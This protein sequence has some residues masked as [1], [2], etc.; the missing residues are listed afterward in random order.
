MTFNPLE[1]L[2]WGIRAPGSWITYSFM[3]G[4]QPASAD[5]PSQLTVAWNDYEKG[6]VRQALE[7]FSRITNLRFGEIALDEDGEPEAE[8]ML[9]LNLLD[10]NDPALLGSC[11]PLGRPEPAQARFN[12]G[13]DSWSRGPGGDLDAGGDGFQTLIHEFGHGLGLSHPHDTGLNGD[14]PIFPGVVDPFGR[15]GYGEHD[16]NQDVWTMMSYVAG[17]PTGPD[18]TSG[19][20]AWGEAMAPMAFD[21][22]VLQAKYG[23]N[24]AWATGDDVYELAD[25]DGPGTGYAAIWDAGGSDTI[26]YGGARDAVI[27]L[28]AATL[29]WAPGGAGQVSYVA[30]VHGG[31]TIAHGVVI[32]NAAG[33]AGDDILRGN[34]ADNILAGGLG[35]DVLEGGAGRDTAAYGVTLAAQSQ[36][37]GMEGGAHVLAG[38]E[39]RD[40][41]RGIEVFAFADG[42]L[43]LDDGTILVDDLL[44]AIANPD[45]W[46]AGLDAE[47]HYGAAGWREG[48]DPNL[49]FST[50]GY[51][52][53]NPDVDAAGVNPLEHYAEQGWREGRATGP[54]FDGALYL[55]RNAD[56]RAAGVNPLEHY[57]AHGAAE[58][59]AIF[60]A[61]GA[62]IEAGFDATFYLLANPDVAAA[63]MAARAHWQGFGAREGRDPNGWFDTGAYLAA[64]ADVALAGLDPLAHYHDWGWREGRAAGPRFDTAAY[65]A[66]HADVAAAGIDPLQHFL[67]FGIHEGRDAP[68]VA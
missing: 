64:N 14:S 34:A 63:G 31:L 1:A 27:D 42:S 7:T 9:V 22:A 18:G 11:G 50:R 65:L 51:L 59:R 12:V 57:L 58:G 53:A 32:E 44:Y 10:M 20:S 54:Q 8:P 19:T 38:A 24:L 28:N 6:Q 4:G 47:A 16:L 41:L 33:G 61:V 13:G 36:A 55:A 43:A 62:D 21:I 5:D 3:A 2:D 15:R 56:V 26:R 49:L 30:G 40:V 25:A 46:A 39:G 67:A 68:P 45:V 37:W 23:A 60:A 66:A 29:L 48:R 17:W 35:D 52:A